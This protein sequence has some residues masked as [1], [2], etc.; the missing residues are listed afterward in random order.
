MALGESVRGVLENGADMLHV[1]VMDGHFVPNLTMGPGIVSA[2]AHSISASLDVHLMVERPE[3]WVETFI[4]AGA[5]AVSFHIE[6]TPH[7]HRVADTIRRRG[8]MAGIALNPGTPVQAVEAV[9]FQVDYVVVMT[10]NPGF[11]GQTFIPMGLEKIRILGELR[12]LRGYHYAIEVDGG[13]KEDTLLEAR[14]AGAEWF[15]AGSAV[16]GSPDPGATVR[17]LKEMLQP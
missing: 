9:L 15:V 16:F 5:Q 14:D 2:L 1:D 7:V 3:N 8:A 10:V 13:V 17:R 4:D 6:A 11:P 12:D